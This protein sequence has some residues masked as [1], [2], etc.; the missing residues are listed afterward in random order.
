[1]GLTFQRSAWRLSISCSKNH[2]PRCKIWCWKETWPQQS[3]K[4]SARPH[5]L[6]K[7]VKNTS[8]STNKTS[9]CCT[10]PCSVAM[11]QWCRCCWVQVTCLNWTR[12][13]SSLH[14]HPCTWPYS[15]RIRTW[16]GLS[17]HTGPSQICWTPIA[18][19]HSITHAS[20]SWCRT[21]IKNSATA[22]KSKYTTTKQARYKRG[23][24]NNSKRS[25]TW[26]GA[27]IGSR[28]TSTLKSCC[29]VDSHWAIQTW[30]SGAWSLH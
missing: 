24:C 1:M 30:S 4:F 27:R 21:N 18:A 19:L 15:S 17:S 10:M 5:K 25:S 11:C 29:S 3:T 13:T 8:P 2:W 12:L 28:P 9:Q 6:L 7:T 22:R 23:L 14:S 20:H 16:C 26:R